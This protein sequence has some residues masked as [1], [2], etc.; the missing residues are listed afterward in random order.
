MVMTCLRYWLLCRTSKNHFIHFRAFHG[1]NHIFLI[2]RVLQ[3]VLVDLLV[4]F[5]D[6]LREL[7]GKP[8]IRH[9]LL[10]D[11]VVLRRNQAFL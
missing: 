1:L 8:R 5:I 4:L 3:Q 6:G 9:Q 7:A 2:S 10:N 11:F